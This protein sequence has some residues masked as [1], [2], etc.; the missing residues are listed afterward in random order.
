MLESFVMKKKI[1]YLSLA[2]LLLAGYNS[3][4]LYTGDFRLRNIDYQWWNASKWTTTPPSNASILEIKAILEQKFTYLARGN[5][6]YAFLSADG[7]YVLKFFRFGHLKPS[8][9]LEWL[10][11]ISP[12][13]KYRENKSSGQEKRLNNNYQGH[14]I[15]STYDADN[16]GL[17]LVHL[18]PTNFINVHTTVIDRLGFSHDI[19]LDAVTFV[20]QKKALIAREELKKLLKM[21]AVAEACERI[22]QIFAL[23]LSEY[24]N[25]VY[26][27][28]HNVIDNIGFSGSRA[29]R[30]DVGKLRFD[31]NMKQKEYYLPDLQEKVVR[32]IDSWV[33]R[34]FPDHHRQIAEYIDKKI[35][36]L[37][38]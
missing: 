11:D 25:G 2:L 4:H 27:R 21:G 20:L 29:M 14:W 33:K 10:P 9:W 7:N 26:D 16:C 22:D 28:D 36:E 17:K 38:N 13:K 24:Q 18:T 23:Y 30:I 6:T 31:E 1:I 35:Q 19:D 37:S 34:D 32:R 12:I 8:P 15:A 5:Q 3:Y